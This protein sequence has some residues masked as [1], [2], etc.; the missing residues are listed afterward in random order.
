M[1]Q[2]VVIDERIIF[3]ARRC[4]RR[5]PPP[6]VDTAVHPAAEALILAI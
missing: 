4:T 6:V 5:L 3:A 2:I 1:G